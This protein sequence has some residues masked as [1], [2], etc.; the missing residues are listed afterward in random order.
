MG[1]AVDIEGRPRVAVRTEP[2]PTKTEIKAEVVFSAKIFGHWIHRGTT[3]IEVR[4]PVPVR[5]EP[6]QNPTKKPRDLL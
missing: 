4:P 6:H 5:A 2:H 1:E 3:D